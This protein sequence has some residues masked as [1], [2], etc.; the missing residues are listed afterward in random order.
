MLESCSKNENTAQ[1]SVKVKKLNKTKKN[2]LMEIQDRCINLVSMNME[3][4]FLLSPDAAENIKCGEKFQGNT[5]KYLHRLADQQTSCHKKSW[6]F[7]WLKQQLYN[8][9]EENPLAIKAPVDSESPW[10]QIS[11]CWIVHQSSITLFAGPSC[12]PLASVV[13]GWMLS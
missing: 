11:G 3:L 2:W 4:L 1:H 10:V 9:I 7:H 13:A 8:L 12:F 6:V 5:R